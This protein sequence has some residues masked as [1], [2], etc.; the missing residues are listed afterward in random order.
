MSIRILL[1]D[2]HKVLCEGLRSVLEREPDMQVVGEAGDGQ[3]ALELTRE[4]SPN[5]VVMDISLP[6]MGGVEATR[7]IRAQCPRVKVLCL[8][9][10]SESRYVSSM[11]AAG[12]CGY[13]PK[14]CAAEELVRA[15]R[16]LMADHAYLSPSITAPVIADCLARSA[17]DS[18][19]PLASLTAREREV[20]QLIAQGYSTQEIGRQLYV[21]IKTVATHRKKVMVKLNVGSVAALTK[22]AM[23]EGLIP[24]GE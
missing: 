6:G 9:M 15:V 3:T 18:R 12:A 10:Y 7:R 5:I 24:V 16:A 23:R 14:D 17:K 20:L 1:A 13:V 8:S 11:L 4:K 21:S 19:S 2:D 22:F